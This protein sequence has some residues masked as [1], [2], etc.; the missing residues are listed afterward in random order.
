MTTSPDLGDRRLFMTAFQVGRLRAEVCSAQNTSH[1][2]LVLMSF[3][4]WRVVRTGRWCLQTRAPRTTSHPDTRCWFDY[5]V[6]C[7]SVWMYVA[8]EVVHSKSIKWNRDDCRLNLSYFTQ[9]E[10]SCWR[11]MKGFH[12]MG[13]VSWRD[14]VCFLVWNA[15]FFVVLSSQEACDYVSFCV[16]KMWLFSCRC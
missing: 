12:G 1:F 8:G 2:T 15:V 14:K 3:C 4:K 13:V 5:A 16:F 11:L 6:A 7:K 9:T 10:L